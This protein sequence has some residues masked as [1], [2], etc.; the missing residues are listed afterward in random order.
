MPSSSLKVQASGS[1]PQPEPR[2]ALCQCHENHQLVLQNT[3]NITRRQLLIPATTCPA[4]LEMLVGAASATQ[5]IQGLPHGFLAHALCGGPPPSHR[6]ASENTAVC[7]HSDHEA[8]SITTVGGAFLRIP[9]H[10]CVRETLLEKDARATRAL[11]QLPL[12]HAAQY[13]A[14]NPRRAV[15]RSRHT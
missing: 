4:C 3:G 9:V 11:L 1:S 7:L 5:G 13:M 6:V 2:A 15:H 12:D 8:T 14:R 10:L